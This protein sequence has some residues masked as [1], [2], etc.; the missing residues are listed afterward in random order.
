MTVAAAI[1]LVLI[2]MLTFLV[3]ARVV[4]ETG[5][6]FAT[7]GAWYLRPWAAAG[8]LPWI[9]FGTTTS[10]LFWTNW[11]NH[12]TIPG[13][14]ESLPVYAT[15]ALCVNDRVAQQTSR[16]SGRVLIL[17]LIVSLAV[18]YVAAGAST[19]YVEYNY[20]STLATP[21]QSPLNSQ[22]IAGSEFLISSVAGEG[23]PIATG[24]RD[25][26]NAPANIGIGAAV[27]VALGAA[28][29][30]WAWWPL[31]PVGYLL[32]QS[33]PLAAAWFSIFAGWLVK[34]L[35]VRFGGAGLFDR[36][37]PVFLGMVAGEAGA[38]ALWML[39]SLVLSS[40]GMDY[41]QIMLLPG[42]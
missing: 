22:A 17:L 18:G 19:L 35:I 33:Y 2:V 11:I 26:H 39:V 4:A 12:L 24:A 3:M 9:G 14:R 25:R 23:S 32:W 27:T 16:T 15:H 1:V 10:S 41:R 40:L 28:R 13:L 42:G 38:A 5:L 34:V 7:I 36:A 29:L 31:H 6:I 8:K 37:R 30:R 21:P 20:A